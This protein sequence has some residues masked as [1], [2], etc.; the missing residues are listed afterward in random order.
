MKRVLIVEDDRD[1]A[2]VLRD[3]LQAE[4]Y[5]VQ[6]VHDGLEASRRVNNG[7]F[8]LIIMDIE[9]P[10]KNGDD[11]CRELKAAGDPTPVLILTGRNERKAIVAGLEI[12]DEYVVKRAGRTEMSELMAR[13]ETLLKNARDTYQFDDIEVDFK[14][15]D[16]LKN[17]QSVEPTNTE[18]TLMKLFIDS[19]GRALT[20]DQLLDGLNRDVDVGRDTI[21]FHIHKL[22][23]KIETDPTKPKYI[24]TVRDFGY[25]FDR[26]VPKHI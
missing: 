22:R 1:L 18:F 17:G 26:T 20:P 19:N 13:I 2:L 3:R 11:I 5:D 23:I 15:R 12:A 9:L 16:I 25:R 24:K 4:G 6:S 14:R 8:D 10:R 7:G 21:K